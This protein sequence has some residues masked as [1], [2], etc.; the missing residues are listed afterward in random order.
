MDKT[1][2]AKAFCLNNEELIAEAVR[3]NEGVIASN[4][5]FSTSTGPRTGRSPNDR[6]IVDEKSTSDL[7]DWGEINKP[8]NSQKFDLL[9]DKVENYISNRNRYTS[10]LHV[11]SHEDHYLPIKVTTETAWHGLFAR[12]IFVVPQEYNPSKKEEWE[13]LSAPNYI[14]IPEEDGTNSDACVIINFEKR[15]VCLLE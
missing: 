13:I 5:A 1:D 10:L 4:G 15:K 9:W 6:F 8:F 7:I 2:T 12:L 3:N 14:C 11:G